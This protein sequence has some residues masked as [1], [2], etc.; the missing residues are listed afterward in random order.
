MT[1]STTDRTLYPSGSPF[2]AAVGFSRAVRVGPFVFVSGTTASGPDGPVGGGDPERQAAEVLAR[3]A[4]ALKE[5]GSDVSQVVRT[6]VYLTDIAHFEAV[7]RAHAAV[8]G[9]IRPASA[10]VEVSAL[11]HPAL[12]VEVEADAIVPQSGA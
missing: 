12:L 4:A 11:A 6:R 5:A 8:F 3:I 9:D 10:F 7:A 2:E 1:L